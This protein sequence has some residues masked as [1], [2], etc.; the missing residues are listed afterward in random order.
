[1]YLGIDEF[2]SVS[3]L[4]DS[5]YNIQLDTTRKRLGDYVNIWKRRI[6]KNKIYYTL[7]LYTSNITYMRHVFNF[8]PA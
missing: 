5:V 1:M 4:Y 7:I 6:L 8:V 2:L 3:I